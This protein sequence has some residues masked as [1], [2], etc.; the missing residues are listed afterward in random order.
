MTLLPARRLAEIAVELASRPGHEK[1]RA[2]IYELLVHGLGARSAEIHFEMPLPEVRGRADAL[3]GLTVFEFKRDLRREQRAAEEELGRYLPQ[4][5]RETGERFIGI[6][7]D[8][9]EFVPYETEGGDLAAMVP[10]RTDP[11][12]P[13]GLLIWLDAAVSL[14]PNLPP[15]PAIVCFELGRDSLAC[16]RALAGLAALWRDAGTLPEARLKRQL[17]ADFLAIVYGTRVDADELFLQHTYLTIVAKTMA[18]RVLSVPLPDPADLLSGKPF[19]EAGIAGA[20]ESDFFDWVLLAPGGAELVGRIAR[21]VTRFHL[22]DVAHDVLKS[23]YETL[24]DP[25]QR[26]DLGEYYT[27]DWLAARV[28]AK[29]IDNP[30]VQRV[31]DPACGSGTFLFH[32]VRRYLEAA[33]TGRQDPGTVLRQCLERIVGIDVHPVAVMVARVTYLLALGQERLRYRPQGISIPVYLGDS[34]QWNTR[35]MFAARDVLIRVPDGPDLVFPERLANE[36]ARFDETVQTMLDLSEQNAPAESL[37]AWLRHNAGTADDR[38]DDVLVATYRHLRQL[39]QSGRNHIWG[40]IVRNLSR[41]LWLSAPAQRADVIVGNPPW[42]CYRYMAAELQRKF[43][44]ECRLR[45]LWTGGKLAA[46]QDLAAYFFVRCTELYL[47][48]QGLI[49]FVMPYGALNRA[50]YAP[51]RGGR[52]ASVE[53]RF[54]AAWAFDERVQPLFP[55]PSAVMFARRAASGPLPARITTFRGALPRRDALLAEAVPVLAEATVPWPAEA[56]LTGG[57]PYRRAFRQGATMVPRRLCVVDRVD[58]GWLGSNARAPLVISRSGRQD[59]APWRDLPPLKGAVEAV[60]LRPLL[61]GESIAPFRVLAPLQAVVPWDPVSNSLLDADAAERCGYPGLS[62]W[63]RLA[64]QLWA[65]HRRGPLSLV[66]RWN[67]LDALRRQLPPAPI[68]VVYAKAGILLAAAVIDDDAAL[69]DHKLYWAAAQSRAE[70]LYLAGLLNSEVI[71]ARI[72][73]LQSRG[74]WGARDFDKVIFELPIPRFDPASADHAG[75]ATAAEEAMA[76]VAALRLPADA[77]FTRARRLVRAAL[78]RAR[79]PRRLDR[80]VRALLSA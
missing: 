4:R 33:E 14:R 11:S 19:R 73:D 26:H 2:L 15:D 49:G 42:L 77:H 53:L 74:R 23:L 32:A 59:K 57:S 31:L 78:A 51:F 45:R 5:E 10:Y 72:A 54:V 1:V 38:E 52:F 60:F 17:W 64:E 6:A 29:A 61:L 24:V 34:L 75:L 36:P 39:K 8:G 40:Y 43:R 80:L 70:A 46:H 27:P 28:C 30:C 66:Q 16:R 13:R 48:P 12:Q 56:Q 55:M 35:Q 63:L 65:R 20:V 44:E 68:R 69:I 7:T 22:K 71:R 9:A 50:Q 67:Y 37:R 47:K 79:L 62:R 18:V 25:E 58:S 21:Q 76:A 41:P 3:L